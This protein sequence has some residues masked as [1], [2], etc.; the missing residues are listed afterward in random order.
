MPDATAKQE[1]YGNLGP[2]AEPS[3][4]SSLA[5]P[6][7]NA[8]HKH[9]RNMM[10]TYIDT[11]IK[12]YMLAWEEAGEAPASERLKWAATGFAFADVPEAY[13]PAS[14]PGPAGIPVAQL[15]AFHLLVMTDESSRIE[16]GVA[17]ALAG[18][19]VIGV[20]PVVEAGSEA[21]KREWLPGLFTWETSYGA[22]WWCMLFC[23][24][25]FLLF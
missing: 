22:G 13:R 20:P 16:G 1:P 25:F 19:S 21:Q 12:P 7:Y 23:L 8:S 18:A 10:R 5:S 9:L 11:H 24:S 4:Y 3:W 15:D 14:V 2:W 17:T 6:Y